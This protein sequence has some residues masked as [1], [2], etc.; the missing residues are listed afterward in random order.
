M[1]GK[2]VGRVV[3]YFV[4]L[5]AAVVFLSSFSVA[6][7]GEKPETLPEDAEL[8]IQENM[9]IREFGEANGLSN[10]VLKEVFSLVTPEDKQGL[11]SST[12]VPVENLAVEVN[13]VLAL[14]P[15]N[16]SINRTRIVMKP[17][18]WA[19]Y[20]VA[21]FL[22]LRKGKITPRLRKG[23]LIGAV[24]L[25]GIILGADP[26]PMGTVRD[27]IVLFGRTGVIIPQ[28]IVAF[29]LMLAGGILLANKFLCAWGCQFGTLQD[30]IFRLNRDSR[31]RRGI[32]PQVKV[33]FALSNSIRIAFFVFMTTA[34]ILW[35]FDVVNFID[36]FK[37]FKPEF[38]GVTGIVSVSLLL[39]ASLFVYRPWCHFL[40]PYG[41]VGWLVEK[42]SINR[43]HVDYESCI[44]CDACS[45]ACPSTAM[46][47]IL[48]RKKTIPDCFSCGTCIGV[49]PTQSISFKKG[50]RLLPPPGKFG[51]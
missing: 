2:S 17:G 44:A 5:V 43:I 38:L 37:I 35:V 29:G 42:I 39:I 11:L 31:D 26:S 14:E 7:W 9:T 20:L 4:V 21:V 40:C 15:E 13:K 36:P 41:L 8:I 46:E 45:K 50:K 51:E 34:A 48:K 12:D 16:V 27:A 33:P 22:L 32:L 24:V 23:L 19:V 28:R 30:L 25:F 10:P 18:L 1:A 49:C 3:L 6:L 47:A